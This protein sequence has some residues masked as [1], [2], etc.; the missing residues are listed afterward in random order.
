MKVTNT[1]IITDPKKRA[2]RLAAIHRRCILLLQASR[3]GR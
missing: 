3:G 1:F 2:A